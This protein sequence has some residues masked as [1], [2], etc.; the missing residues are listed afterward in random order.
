M[1][2]GAGLLLASLLLA[3]PA[4]FGADTG[5]PTP[6]PFE[7]VPLSNAEPRSYL[8]AYACLFA[9]AVLIGSSF[10]I[11]DKAD[12]TYDDYLA[13]TDP[14][15]IDALY[16]R[17]VTYDRWGRVTLL[18]GE[19]LVVAGLYLRFLHR[20]ASRSLELAVSPQRW[21]LRARF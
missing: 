7:T 12:E 17:T 18:G 14:A 9:G 1:R 8:G 20:P 3:P 5:Q 4:A 19:A 2:R 13:A 10:V 16:S 15:E 21:A 11:Q 6:S